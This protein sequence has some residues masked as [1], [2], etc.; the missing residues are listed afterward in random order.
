MRYLIP[1]ASAAYLE[2]SRRSLMLGIVSWGQFAARLV[3]LR[4]MCNPNDPTLLQAKLLLQVNPETPEDEWP[5]GAWSEGEDPNRAKE[6]PKAPDQDDGIFRFIPHGNTG[7]SNWVFHPYDPD[8]FPSV[9][10]GHY[11]GKPQPKLDA[12]LGWI[13]KGAQQIS[14][15]DRWKIVALWNDNAFRAVALAAINYY[16]TNF[17]SYTGWRVANPK[18]LPRRRRP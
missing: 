1:E 17:P 2:I 14:R 9:P 11:Q 15:E 3:A 16:L 13:Y 8:H 10:H 7:L 4:L 5:E 6:R 18:V 12:Y